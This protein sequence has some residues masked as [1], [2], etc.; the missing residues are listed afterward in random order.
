MTTQEFHASHPFRTAPYRDTGIDGFTVPYAGQT[1]MRL[2]IT[3]GMADARIRIDP[4]A[5]DLIAIDCGDGM[6]PRLRVSASEL[7]VSWPATTIGSWLR[8]AFAGESRDIE[9]VLHPAV[10]WTLQIRGGLSHFEAD[11]TS[12]KLARVEISGGVS[13]ARFDLPAPGGIV[14]IRISGGASDL[15]LRRP[16]ESGVVVAVSGGIAGLRLDDQAFGAIGGGARLAT[17]AIH[18]EPH[19]SLELSG[20]ASALHVVSQ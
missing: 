16:A 13:D 3:S 17:G 19:Y 4:E 8:S 20:G 6:P 11:L 10:E 12:G 14:P 15:A 7:R 18:G 5:T 1:R 2:T 9:I